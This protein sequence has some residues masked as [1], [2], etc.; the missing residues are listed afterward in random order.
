MDP[1]SSRTQ[2]FLLLSF[3]EVQRG[4]WLV[5]ILFRSLL[6]RGLRGL[7]VWEMQLLLE[8]FAR[9]LSAVGEGNAILA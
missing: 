1:A 6:A 3:S 7:S 5:A 8:G 4:L 9:G 2:S